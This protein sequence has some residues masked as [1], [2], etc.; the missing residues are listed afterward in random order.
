MCIF[1]YVGSDR[2]LPFRNW[3]PPDAEVGI[4]EAV[5]EPDVAAVF[6]KPFVYTVGTRLTGD[7]CGFQGDHAEARWAREE[8][9]AFLDRA[10][11]LVPEV[12]LFVAWHDFGD[13]GVRPG[14]YDRLGPSDIRLWRSLFR[15]DE[16]LVVTRD[17]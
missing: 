2:E 15:P 16:F 3:V 11:E 8:L 5:R 9:A 10:L 6:S 12:E 17:E 13:S 1:L 14:S 4:F 7:G